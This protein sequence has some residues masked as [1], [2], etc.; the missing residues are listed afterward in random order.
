MTARLT[1]QE[2]ANLNQILDCVSSVI[3]N[4]QLED[5]REDVANPLVTIMFDDE[6]KACLRVLDAF[7]KV[8]ADIPA[9]I[10]YSQRKRNYRH[11]APK[12]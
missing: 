11:H 12:N 8:K 9:I 1:A 10:L 4:G 3:F 6:R 2:H 5:F 7:I